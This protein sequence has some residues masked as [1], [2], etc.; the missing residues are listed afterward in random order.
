MKN[1][2][3]KFIEMLI[4]N[5][6]IAIGISLGVLA[7]KGIDPGM[8][9]FYGM[10]NIVGQSLGIVTVLFNLIFLLPL[11]LFDRSRIGIATLVNMTCIGFFV[12]FITLTVFQGKIIENIYFSYIVLMI[13]IILQSFGVAMY[14]NA[15]MG[16][17]PL[18]GIPNVIIKAVRKGN[19][20]VYRVLQ[21]C[22][23]VLI[24]VLCG[25]HIGIG[26][27]MLMVLVGPCIYFFQTFITEKNMYAGV[28]LDT[29]KEF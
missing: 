28:Q 6:I 4:G 7:N 24:G 23:L 11:L 27:I 18:D 22:T 19:Y 5:F 20:R 3:A 13:G 17:S 15:N 1:K 21:D 16:Q 26:T 12:E 14:S 8:T 29:E 25:A 2:K 10:S 9:F